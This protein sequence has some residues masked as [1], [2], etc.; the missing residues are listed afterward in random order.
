MSQSGLAALAGVDRGTIR[1]LEKTLGNSAPSE[2]LEP[3]V[4]KALTLGIDEFTSQGKPLGNLKIYK[5]AY[6]AAVLKHFADKEEKE[7]KRVLFFAYDSGRFSRK[8]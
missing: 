3:F 4:G 6:C 2:S 1:N 8:T 5:S 7:T